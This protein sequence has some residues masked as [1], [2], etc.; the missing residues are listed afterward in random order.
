MANFYGAGIAWGLALWI[1][2]SLAFVL[3]HTLLWSGAGKVAR[4]ALAMVLM[5]V[6]PFGIVGWAHPIT[7]AGVVFPGWGWPGL[8]AAAIGLLIMTTRLW[9]IAAFVLGALWIWSASSWAVPSLPEGWRGVDTQLGRALGR[10]TGLEPQRDLIGVVRN[11]KAQGARVVVLPESALG[12]WTQTMERVWVHA[13]QGSAVTVIAGAAIIDHDGYDNVMMEITARGSRVLY[14]ERMPIPVS[15]W[16]PWNSWRGI[17]SGAQ[18]YF[19]SNSIVAVDGKR[20]VPLICYEQLLVWP[21]LHSMLGS[22]EIIIAIGNGW[23]TRS[24]AVV[25]IQEASVRAWSR[26]FGLPLVTAFNI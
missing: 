22:P 7:A 4:Y 17:E 10:R 24:L 14:R 18:A 13:L 23:W 8:G 26:L 16:Q 5:A 12:F 21:V 15:M 19:F 20:S 6:P 9:P 1:G 3:V 25:A 11:A 2:A